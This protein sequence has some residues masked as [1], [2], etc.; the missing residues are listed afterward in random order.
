MAVLGIYAHFHLVSLDFIDLLFR[1]F[2]RFDILSRP[3]DM[4]F[5]ISNLAGWSALSHS[6]T[7]SFHYHIT[8]KVIFLLKLK[9]LQ[10]LKHARAGISNVFFRHGQGLFELEAN[11][12]IPW[13]ESGILDVHETNFPLFCLSYRVSCVQDQRRRCHERH[14]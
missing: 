12:P 7:H 9:S 10:I 4:A 5:G 3:V 13:R 14:G 2:P 8:F 11:Q 1:L 6:C